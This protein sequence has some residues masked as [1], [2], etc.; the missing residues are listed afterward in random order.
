[1]NS[2]LGAQRLYPYAPVAA[3]TLRRVPNAARGH[4]FDQA[5]TAARTASSNS[6]APAH[7]RT[8]LRT[9]NMLESCCSV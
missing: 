4:L 2:R 5:A 9:P 8:T 6:D 3:L 1:M 7:F